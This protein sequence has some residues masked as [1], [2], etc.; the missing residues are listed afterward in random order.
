MTNPSLLLLDE[1][2]EGLAPVI[3]EELYKAIKAM[4][5]D[6]R[7][8]IIL[9]EQHTDLALEMTAEGIVLERAAIAHRA[10][11]EALRQDRAALE[12]LVGLRVNA[13]A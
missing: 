10:A 11:T 6:R 1:P 2:M 9:V 12:R 4:L 7:L 13:P 5:A 8:A 3:V